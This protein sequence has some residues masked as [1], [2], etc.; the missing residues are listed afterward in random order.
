MDFTSTSAPWLWAYKS[1]SPLSSD[2]KSAAITQHDNMGTL[3]VDLTAATGGSSSNPFLAS[4]S[5]SSTAPGTSTDGVTIQQSANINDALAPV[6]GSLGFL[7][8]A[9]LFPLGAIVLRILSF[10]G[11]VWAHVAIQALSYLIA[12]TVLGT[13]VYMANAERRLTQAHPIIGLVVIAALFLQPILGILHH[14]SYKSKGSS[15][16]SL[17]HVWWGR[18]LI[19]LGIINGG[20]GLQLSATAGRNIEIAYGVVAGSMWLLWMGSALWVGWRKRKAGG[21][22]ISSG[23]DRKAAGDE[24]ESSGFAYPPMQQAMPLD[25]WR[26]QRGGA[27]RYQ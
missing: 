22:V 10:R 19:T 27:P 16:W 12:I 13:G 15:I 6:H 8:F 1:D 25:D 17:P 4:K 18:I 21:H 24:S 14:R 2:S 5:S 9:I 23:V 20:L 3:S 26:E 7:S 11:V